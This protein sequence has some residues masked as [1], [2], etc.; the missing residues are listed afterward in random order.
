[1]KFFYEINKKIQKNLYIAVL[2]IVKAAMY[3]P[4]VNLPQPGEET[5]ESKYIPDTVPVACDVSDC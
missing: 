1:M 5:V 4:K 3:P 2:V